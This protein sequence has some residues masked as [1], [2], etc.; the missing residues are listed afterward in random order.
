MHFSNFQ[1]KIIQPAKSSTRI[2]LRRGG[3]L[4]QNLKYLC[5]KN[6][7]FRHIEQ[8]GAIQAY[9]RRELSRQRSRWFG[10]KHTTF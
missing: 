5:S 10:E 2:L 4:G 9:H 7:S 8:T 1:G 3:G 6:I